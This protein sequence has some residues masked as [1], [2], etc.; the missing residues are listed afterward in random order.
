MDYE[1]M[2][3]Y[4]FCQNNIYFYTI[5]L[6]DNSDCLFI[7]KNIWEGKIV[8]IFRK[9][10]RNRITISKVSMNMIVTLLIIAFWG[11]SKV[12]SLSMNISLVLSILLRSNVVVGKYHTW[13]K[14]DQ[15]KNHRIK[16]ISLY[17]LSDDEKI[18][19]NEG[20]CTC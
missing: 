9:I 4:I 17:H 2:C 14:F 16:K 20:K 10:I 13:T 15:K 1:Y 7:T 18:K 8:L 5:S 19:R 3:L 12:L 11:E 6:F